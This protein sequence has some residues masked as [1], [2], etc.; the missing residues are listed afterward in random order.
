MEGSPSVGERHVHRQGAKGEGGAQE[1]VP[2]LSVP[3]PEEGHEDSC[4]KNRRR[5]L[6]IHLWLSIVF[7]DGFIRVDPCPN[8]PSYDYACSRVVNGR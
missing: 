8:D 3:P 7:V 4:R 1:K 6:A 2:G 5:Q